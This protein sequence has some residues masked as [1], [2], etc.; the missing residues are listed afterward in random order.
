[1]LPALDAYDEAIRHSIGLRMQKRLTT[2]QAEEIAGCQS[3]H[4][5]ISLNF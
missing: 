2:E 1:M 3:V 4:R 5:D